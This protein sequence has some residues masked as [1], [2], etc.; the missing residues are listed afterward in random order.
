MDLFQLVHVDRWV[1]GSFKVCT[2]ISLT[3]FKTERSRKGGD[4]QIIISLKS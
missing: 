2:N 4:L 3:Q 1:S